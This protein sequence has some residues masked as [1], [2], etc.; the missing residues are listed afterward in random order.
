[1]CVCINCQHVHDCIIYKI[2]QQQHNQQSSV[3]HILFFI[4]FQPLIE[5]NIYNTSN[6]I[7]T[8][9]DL[10]ECLSFVEQPGYWLT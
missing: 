3:Q 4:P 6:N 1:M 8:E 9:W 2:I 5:V 10:V 7:R